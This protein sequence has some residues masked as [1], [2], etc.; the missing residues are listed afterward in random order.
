MFCVFFNFTYMFNITFLAYKMKRRLGSLEE[1]EFEPLTEGNHLDITI[2]ITGWLS[3]ES[4]GTFC[5]NL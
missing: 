4:R 5:L 1:F 3:E 2:A